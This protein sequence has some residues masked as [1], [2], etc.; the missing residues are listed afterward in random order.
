[1]IQKY[2]RK[3][4]IKQKIPLSSFRKVQQAFGLFFRRLNA[5]GIQTLKEISFTR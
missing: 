3:D 5:P 1:M 4:V 2:L